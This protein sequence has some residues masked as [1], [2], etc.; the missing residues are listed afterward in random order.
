MGHIEKRYG[1]YR[2]RYRDPLGR[3]HSK[4]FT[5]KTDAQRFLREMQVDVDRGRW[6]DP[7]GA[8][9]A[10]EVWAEECLRLARRL[11]PSTQETYRRDL[12]R[13]ILPM[14]AR[15][16]SGACRPTR[17]STGRTTGSP[18]VRTVVG[19]SPLPDPAAHAAGGSREGED[20]G[21][22]V[23]PRPAASRP[24]PRDGLPLVGAGGRPGRGH[25]GLV[26]SADLPGN[27]FRDALERAGG[28]RP[29][30]EEGA[31]DRAAHSAR[32]G[33]VAPQGDED[34]RRCPVDHDLRCDC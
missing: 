9:M 13:Y 2:T 33:G 10:L 4:T 12:R 7:A 29:T 22:P 31:G 1:N 14:F 28:G 20:P 24:S 23:R 18:P 34:G 6:L 21:Q 17:S 26:S 27:R 5:R 16:G 30:A 8:D 19:P 15:A 3:Q 11:S 25:D 32:G